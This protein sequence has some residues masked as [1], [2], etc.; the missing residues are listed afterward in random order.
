MKLTLNG[1]ENIRVTSDYK[2]ENFVDI[3]SLSQEIGM[4]ID[5]YSR[6]HYFE[7][8]CNEHGDYRMFLFVRKSDKKYYDY[9]ELWKDSQVVFAVNDTKMS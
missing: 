3:H 6:F 9:G 8:R 1:T 7:I 5:L 4:A 2:C